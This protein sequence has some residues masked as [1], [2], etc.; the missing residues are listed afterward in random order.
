MCKA[1]SFYTILLFFE[2]KVAFPLLFRH[3]KIVKEH[4]GH[5]SFSSK[6]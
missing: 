4:A 2:K 3:N 5:F 1:V 6:R